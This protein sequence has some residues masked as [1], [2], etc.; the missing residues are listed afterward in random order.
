MK[1]A[2]AVS[3][4]AFLEKLY[5][6]LADDSLSLYI[7][8]QPEGNSFLIK[9]VNYLSEY[10][11]PKYFKHNNVQ[12][13]I[14]Q[15]NMYS[16]TKTRHDSNYREFRHTLFMRG[17]RDLIVLIKRKTQS[18]NDT[19][20]DK[21]IKRKR[22][23][24][25]TLADSNTEYSVVTNDDDGIEN[26][27][28]I[29]KYVTLL[30]SQLSSLTE[31]YRILREDYDKLKDKFE[32][33]TD[34]EAKTTI[35]ERNYLEQHP[36]VISVD[37]KDISTGMIVRMVS[38][39]STSFDLVDINS[40][41]TPSTSTAKLLPKGKLVLLQ[42]TNFDQR[43]NGHL[44]HETSGAWDYHDSCLKRMKSFDGSYMDY[45]MKEQRVTNKQSS[46]L[47]DLIQAA[48]YV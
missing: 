1:V 40:T 45:S 42:D 12:S 31:K 41:E 22:S 11:L 44:L 32:N 37:N 2:S 46:T 7:A 15:L 24:Y 33:S 36:S 16:F 3:A 17:R 43:K 13:F 10:I 28:D 47:M 8:W 23:S 9:D 5:E 39:E 30:E 20:S 35:C 18:N 27:T 34:N 29:N 21:D 48:E 38:I 4:P 25:S 14:R 19:C 26:S 6:I